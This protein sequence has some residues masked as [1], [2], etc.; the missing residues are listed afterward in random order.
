VAS[1][2]GYSASGE[3]NGWAINPN[4][5][6]CGWVTITFYGTWRNQDPCTT[7]PIAGGTISISTNF[8]V[9]NVQIFEPWKA[10]CTNG[11]TSF[12]LTNTCGTVTWEVSPI[13]PGG[14]YAQGS[15]IFAGTNCGT[16][17]VTAR[18]TVNTN[19]TGSTTLYVVE[20]DSISVD[21]A[22]YV[23]SNNWAAVKT[24]NATDYVTLTANLCP[25]VTNAAVLFN[26]SGGGETVPDNPLQRRVHKNASVKTTVSASCC[27]NSTNVNIWI[28]W[29]TVTV[30]SSGT[31]PAHAVQF[32]TRYDGTEILGGRIY[33]GG[34][35]GV[36]KV[37]PIAQLT[38]S[39]V[40]NVATNGWTFRR[41]RWFH[42]FD[43]GRSA[44]ITDASWTGDTSDPGFQNLT[45][46]SSDMIYDR[47]AP[48]VNQGTA[49]ACAEVY[50]KFHQW[51]EWNGTQASDGSP[52]TD[53]F[54]AG[55]EWHWKAKWQATASPQVIL[56]NVG[57]G[58]ITLPNT[59]AGCP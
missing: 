3:Y 5:P 27:G 41:E 11:S 43:D 19:C 20:L 47:D 58:Y 40:H 34:A 55:A 28:I 29:G 48:N 36:G 2:P 8:Y 4:P 42:S 59:A 45:P 9:A 54:P 10:V 37:V 50:A 15:T 35:I 12:T 14:P 52:G 31:T 57:G 17:T 30:Q 16:Y 38:P 24:T 18:S 39:G 49:N 7:L 44:D 1:G 53:T 22:T 51:I 6:N 32:G 46:D 25:F 23:S 21:A 26:W 56:T 13:I 33:A